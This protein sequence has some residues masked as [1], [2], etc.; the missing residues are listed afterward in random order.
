M[1]VSSASHAFLRRFVDVRPAEVRALLWSFAY[2]FC[3]LCAYYI[4]RPVREEM[5][6][7]GGLENLPWMFTA[8]FLAM[9]AAVPL[10][11]AVVAR[12]PRK[13]FIPF[14][15][16]FFALHLCLFYL[17]LRYGISPALV[18]RVFYVWLNVFNLFIVS[19]FWS[20]MADLWRSEQ[21]K[22]LFGFIAAGGS[23][24]AI[25]GPLF[26]ARLVGLIGPAT[27]LLASVV[28]LELALLCF[29]RVAGLGPQ[30][31]EGA[32]PGLPERGDARIGGGVFSVFGL[33]VRSPYL[34]GIC[35]QTVLTT[36]TATVL[37]FQQM[38]LIRAGIP[39]SAQRT[40]LFAQM[41]LVVNVLTIGLQALATG[42]IVGK[43]G[44]A[45][46]L[47]VV[48]AVTGL[49]FL[50]LAF[51]PVLGLVVAF[52]ALRRS[53]HYAV[54]RPAR[55]I[56]F[57]VVSDEE[58]YKSKSFIDTVVYR[59]SDAASGWLYTALSP[60]LSSAALSLSMIPIA[61]VWIALSSRLAREQAARARP[62]EMPRAAPPALLLPEEGK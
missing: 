4:L 40:A 15:Y 1:H 32:A 19:I 26:T 38:Q 59:G 35:A 48:P 43:V 52:Q 23:A 22:R 56:L 18:A 58:K 5:G 36:F 8:T 28:L 47:A 46:A 30:L 16:R 45:V 27:L 60:R 50:G 57:T 44:L 17:G 34:L 20:V 54:E 21:G 55:E 39:D 33:V 53:T 61:C 37:Y 51:V 13:S 12:F 62:V 14:A 6:I 29:R 10:Y 2:F 25:V 41:D 11:G 24:G 31:H 7:T 3:L 49:G 42:R 9:L